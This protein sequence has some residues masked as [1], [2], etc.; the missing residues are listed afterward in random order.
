MTKRKPGIQEKKKGGCRRLDEVS[1]VVGASHS[2]ASR[3]KRGKTSLPG[4][5]AR[6]PR[7]SDIGERAKS[8]EWGRRVS[9]DTAGE[10]AIERPPTTRDG[11]FR[12]DGKEGTERTGHPAGGEC[13]L[14]RAE[15]VG[16]TLSRKRA[17]PSRRDG[18]RLRTQ[19]CGPRRK[20]EVMLLDIYFSRESGANYAQADP[21]C[22]S[23][24][25]C[26]FFTI[27][28]P[29]QFLLLFGSALWHFFLVRLFL[30]PLLE[31]E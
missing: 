12:C 2:R 24:M 23:S 18:L 11:V 6:Q 3:S 13:E 22:A 28:F 25:R 5:H 14:V 30:F 4:K 27:S 16:A 9:G 19:F 10:E 17:G 29:Y 21:S 8:G 1:G 15:V 31:G 7:H 20:G 26:F